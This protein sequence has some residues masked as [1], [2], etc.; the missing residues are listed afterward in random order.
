MISRVLRPVAALLSPLFPIR[1]GLSAALGCV[2]SGSA[3]PYDAG[4]SAT[5]APTATFRASINVMKEPFEDTFD[6]PDGSDGTGLLGSAA[7]ASPLLT[8]AREGGT[9]GGKAPSGEAGVG[10]A[11]ALATGE[12][13]AD[14]G[15]LLA[16]LLRGEDG[17]GEASYL[18][19]HNMGPNWYPARTTAWKI[20]NGRLCGQNAR[21]HGVWLQ[22]TLPINAR[23]EFDAVAL[24]DEGDLKTEVW[25][26]GQSAATTMSY[27]N[28]TS[29]LAILGGWKNRY[30]VLARIDEH[31]K[32]RKEI[33]V[34]KDSDDPKQRPVIRGQVYHFKVERTDG[35]SVRFF[36]DGVEYH[37]Y[38]DPQPLIGMGH[39]H[40][41]FNNWEVK[42]CYDSVKITPL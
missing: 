25:G 24:S 21:N 2:P 38:V 37:S 20:E 23:V 16:H 35:R 3:P 1:L 9:E 31:G 18:P 7:D 42:T 29:Y 41:G 12:G 30:H 17:P 36:V 28:A 6:R 32:D 22:R 39:D 40:V 33:A 27:T 14:G 8:I 13:G 5:A 10:E 34:D 4:T 26:D 19:S 15:G 11:G